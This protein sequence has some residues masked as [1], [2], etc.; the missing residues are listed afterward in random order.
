MNAVIYCRISDD[1]AGDSLGVTRQEADCRTLCDRNGWDV[2]EVLVD[3]D[4]SAYSGRRRPAYQE[5]LERLKAGAVQAVVAW[6]PDRLHRSPRELEAFIDL[7]DQTGAKVETVQA[8]YWDLSTPS[9]RLVARQLGAVARYESEHKAE[10]QRRKHQELFEQGRPAG[11]DRCFGYD[12]ITVVDAEAALIRTAVDDLLAGRSLR[13]I[14]TRW[15]ELGVTTTF[16]NP[17]RPN[18]LRRLVMSAHIAGRRERDGW[19]VDAIWPAIVPWET[20]QRL[21]VILTDPARRMNLRPR[22]YLLTGGLAVCGRCGGRL[23]ARPKDTGARCYVCAS[24]V[25]THGCGGIRLL[26][27]DFEEDAERRLLVHLRRLVLPRPTPDTAR[28]VAALAEDEAALADLAVDFYANRSIGRA[29]FTAATSKLTERIQA[30]RHQIAA[31]E[32]D[33][34]A[35]EWATPQIAADAYRGATLEVK[36]AIWRRYAHAV[37]VGPAVRGRN[38]Y[39]PARVTVRWR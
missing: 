11:G 12:G 8:G 14:C 19:T 22:S 2:T 4:R 1:R 21:R 5:L 36:R 10:R 33:R 23:V 32:G 37:E 29:Q 6:H 35:A 30:T 34:M 20:V 15:N 16:G 18:V 24:G 7:L 9:G 38:F 17:W 39:D 27:D 25:P 13:S 26:A 31:A 3:N 28:L